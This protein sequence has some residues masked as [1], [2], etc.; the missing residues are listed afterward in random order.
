MI[1]STHVMQ[2]KKDVLVKVDNHENSSCTSNQIINRILFSN[3]CS[4]IMVSG[5]ENSNPLS[6]V[7]KLYYLADNIKSVHRFPN[8]HNSQMYAKFLILKDRADSRVLSPE[9]DLGPN[10][11]LLCCVCRI[12]WDFWVSDGEET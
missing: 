9:Q 12:V 2:S 8:T 10:S 5:M 6:Q 7:Q 3:T 11:S 4:T 1:Q